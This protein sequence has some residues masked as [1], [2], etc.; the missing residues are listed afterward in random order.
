MNYK[1][2]SLASGI[3]LF[4]TLA[5]CG[6]S[7]SGG[8][9]DDGLSTIDRTIES[10][11]ITCV[12]T[13]PADNSGTE[14]NLSL[15]VAGTY[16]SGN[17]FD[18]ASAEIVTYDSCLDRLYVIN[19]EEKTVDVLSLD[20][21]SS[22][23]S[24]A[25]TIDLQ[26]AAQDAGIAIG[27]AN[28]VSAKRGLVAVAIEA[29]TKQD[30]GI[31]AL[32]KSDDLSLLATYSTGA[33]PDSITISENGQYIV[34]AN[35]GEPNGE[36]TVDPEGSVTII[37]IENGVGA[38]T[39]VV[40]QVSFAAFNTDGARAGEM[41]S[42]V[43]LPGPA[44]TTVA[45]DLEPEFVA[46]I[47]ETGKAI[48]AL[49]EN[50]AIAIVDIASASVDAF[51]GLGTK[52]WANAELDVTNKDDAYSPSSYPQLVGYYMPDTIVAAEIDGAN[53]ILSANEGDGREYVYDAT[54]AACDTAGHEWDEDEDYAPGGDDEDA[55][56]YTTEEGD[57]ISFTDEGRGKDLNV[58][59]AHPLMD[60]ATLGTNLISNKNELGRIKVIMDQEDVAAD[61]NVYT[62]G[63]RSFSIWDANGD[64]VWDSGDELSARAY[65]ADNTNFNT[66]NDN[67]ES[68]DDRSD[69]KGIEPEAL[70]VAT[71]NGQTFAF[72]GLERQ[73]G[74]MVYN[75][76]TPTEPTFVQ[77]IN[78]RDF[79]ESVCTVVDDG[80]CDN[81]TYNQAA[82]D[83]A[84]ESIEYFSRQGEHFIAVGNEVSGTTTV[85]SI[86]MN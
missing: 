74:V 39:A 68:A 63:A 76:S 22:V 77:Y 83:L 51:K 30:N 84:P 6:G 47:E 46:I 10:L 52:S 27:A 65:A 40:E 21:T 70:E 16:V 82:L 43:R 64:L 9:S 69:D 66:T 57:C 14:T 73:G 25:A 59:D 38:D 37:N 33:L 41:P 32:Y 67:N 24:K 7:S 36:Y 54:Q 35:E 1:L 19:A 85:Y 79:S 2:T 45:Q 58:A 17:E 20:E 34:T 12:E 60:E 28:S 56:L 72:I 53:Y 71:I 48:I 31:V 26:L 50:N 61:E 86:T 78:N 42:N 55:T 62:F 23:P 29:E 81:D 5:G 44:G 49:Q 13:S 4:G 15:S 8:S 18:T 80:D 75:I 11:S 3:V